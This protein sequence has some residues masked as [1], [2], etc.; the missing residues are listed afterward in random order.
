MIDYHINEI[1][2]V[3][4]IGNFDDEYVYDI[5]MEDNTEHTYF[6]N[7]ILVHNSIYITIAPVLKTLGKELCNEKGDV[8][9]D[10]FE[11]VKKIEN[12]LNTKIT[13]WAKKI[14]NIK[15]PKFVFKRET[16]CNSGLFLEKKRYIL[17]VL[18]D[19]GLKPDE[20]KEIKYTG[21][22]VVSIK[23]PKKVKPLIKNISKVMLKTRDKK[24]TDEA[25]KN[26]Y[27]EY[28]KLDVEDVATPMGINNYET[29]ESKANGFDVAK[30]TPMHVSSAIYYNTLLNINGLTN[31]YEKIVSGDAIKIF[32]VE[33]NKYNIKSIA[34]KDR[35]PKEFGINMDKVKMFN[36]TV[37]PA[38][39]RLY[40]A[41]G[42]VLK[43]PTEE[44][45]CD[46]LE[47]L[48]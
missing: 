14:C 13:E 32:Y 47:L 4:C 42:W 1:E 19:E 39:E 3:E 11:I 2:S 5:E 24:K 34:F 9:R 16:I 30:S 7:D 21:V 12:E 17:H 8:T 15:D 29:Y 10:A 18:D 36:K 25:Y 45:E 37:S 43:N 46:L 28:L 48:G 26:A 6:A 22:E 44:N 40:E 27:E 41:V 20:E 38:V 31:K 33:N 35:Y 23:I